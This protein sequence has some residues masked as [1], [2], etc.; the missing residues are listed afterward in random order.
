MSTTPSSF[1]LLRDGI[2]SGSTP[3]AIQDYVDS[4]EKLFFLIL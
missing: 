2:L 4:S 3:K 1:S